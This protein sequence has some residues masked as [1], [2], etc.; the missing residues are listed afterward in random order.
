[1]MFEPY[2]MKG[3]DAYNN[4]D[5]R[6]LR[7][8]ELIELGKTPLDLWVETANFLYSISPT[9]P[10][11]VMLS[12]VNPDI[13]V[14]IIDDMRRWAEAEYIASRSGVLVRVDRPGREPVSNIDEELLSYDSWDYVISNDAGFGELEL[15]VRTICDDVAKQF[16]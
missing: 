12:R 4:D 8:I 10:L 9:L 11:Q 5:G 13:D 15:A 1:M 7:T 6:R 2:G 3:A 16:T 14:V